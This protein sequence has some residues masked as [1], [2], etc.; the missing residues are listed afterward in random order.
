MPPP[1]GQDGLGFHAADWTQTRENGSWEAPAGVRARDAARARAARA[2]TGRRCAAS[3][4]REPP[5]GLP[6]QVRDEVAAGRM[7]I[8]ANKVHLGHRLD[9]MAIGRA[10]KTKINANMGASPVRA[11]PSRRSRSSRG[12]SAGARTP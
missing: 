6:E 3:A 1:S 12:R 9:P 2:I 4:E 10:S 5:P 7:V 11:A 8:P